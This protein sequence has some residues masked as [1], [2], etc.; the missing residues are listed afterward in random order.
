MA[1]TTPLNHP[2][3]GQ[4]LLPGDGAMARRKGVITARVGGV[5][6]LLVFLGILMASRVFLT[7][8]VTGL[9]TRIADLESRREFLEAGNADLHRRWNAASSPRVVM[10]RAERELGLVPAEAPG[11]VLVL[12]PRD[13]QAERPWQ[14]E[15]AE[16][17]AG[18]MVSLRPRA[19]WAEPVS[20]GDEK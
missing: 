13:R 19:A 3:S 4:P 14:E 5:A 16:V 12:L 8:Q 15:V 11:P 17:V 10:A 1:G 20:G 6:A 18:T 2:Y 7:S 9:R